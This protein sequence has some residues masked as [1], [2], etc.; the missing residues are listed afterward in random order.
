MGLTEADFERVTSHPVEDGVP[1]TASL[2]HLR[3]ENC[4]SLESFKAHVVQ[5]VAPFEKRVT[6]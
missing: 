2:A 4:G 5:V 3:L 6:V 1:V